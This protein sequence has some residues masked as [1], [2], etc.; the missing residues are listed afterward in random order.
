M[1]LDFELEHDWYEKWIPPML[2]HIELCHDP[3]TGK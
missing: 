3:G 1:Y 2:V